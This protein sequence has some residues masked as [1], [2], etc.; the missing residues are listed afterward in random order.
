LIFP[1]NG[2][3]V[4]ATGDVALN[5]N[6]LFIKPLDSTLQNLSGKFSFSNGDLQ[7]Q[8]MTATWFNQPLKVDFN[9]REGEKSYQV[10]VNMDANWQPSRTGVLPKAI[11]DEISGSVPWQ[12]KVAIELPY[13]GSPTY[14]VGVTAD[15]KNVSSHLP[16][17]VDKAAGEPL[18]VKIDV[19]GNLKSFD[20]TG[21]VGSNNHLN[22]RWLLNQ[23]LTLDRAIW[24]SDSRTNPPLPQQQGVELNL[25]PMDGAQW[26]A[27]FQQGAASDAS[28]AAVFPKQV[29]LR[30]PS[31]TLGGQQWN[32]LSIV[33]QPSAQGTKV[34]AQGREVN[35]TLTMHDNAPWQAAIRYLYYNPSSTPLT[36]ASAP[37]TGPLTRNRLDFSGWPDLQLRCAECWLWGQKYG[38]IDGDFAIKGDTLTD[39]RS[40]GYR[41]RAADQRRRMG[42]WPE[43]PAH[44]VERK[45]ARQEN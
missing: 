20:L 15:L 41:L 22:S 35:A 30:T 19:D 3:L 21:K 32:N 2:E 43:R 7:S 17:P 11:N 14:K 31:L 42:E 40:G 44:V 9:T 16:A 8:P 1:L 18:P 23:K 45:T 26:L 5:N 25:P 33:S 39:E 12:G 28:S 34:D 24:A 37:S 27:L 10:G 13:R 29:T 4:H 6:S 38:R 36:Q